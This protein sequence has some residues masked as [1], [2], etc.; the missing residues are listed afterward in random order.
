MKKDKKNL[1]K[2]VK[3]DDDLNMVFPIT[4]PK[5]ISEILK[6][7][8]FIDDFSKKLSKLEFYVHALELEMSKIDAFKRELPYSMRLLEDGIIVNLFLF[9]AFFFSK[10]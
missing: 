3:M 8:S 5:K 7:V 6:E 2:R 10:I 9:F 4:V 1:E